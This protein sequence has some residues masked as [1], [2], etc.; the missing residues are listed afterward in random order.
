MERNEK[1]GGREEEGK[2]G[3]KKKESFTI[4][5]FECLKDCCDFRFVSSEK[6]AKKIVQLT[7]ANKYLFHIY[8]PKK[9]V[10]LKELISAYEYST[11]PR[12]VIYET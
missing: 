2:K 6:A 5:D 7:N 3:K 4:H 9:C 11:E 1:L 8:Y 12:C 10:P